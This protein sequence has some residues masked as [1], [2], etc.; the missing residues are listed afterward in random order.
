[1]SDLHFMGFVDRQKFVDNTDRSALFT[2]LDLTITVASGD[3]NS[4]R[5]TGQPS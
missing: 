1:M 4:A 2:A 5:Y 3:K